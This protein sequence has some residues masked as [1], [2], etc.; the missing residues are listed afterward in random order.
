MSFFFWFIC[1]SIYC[2]SFLRHSD[3][4]P[5]QVFHK[6]ARL[7]KLST[8]FSFRLF[9]AYRFNLHVSQFGNLVTPSSENPEYKACKLWFCSALNTVDY[10]QTTKKKESRYKWNLCRCIFEGIFTYVRVIFSDE[11]S[12][13]T[14]WSWMSKCI[15]F[16]WESNGWIKV[17][18]RSELIINRIIQRLRFNTRRHFAALHTTELPSYWSKC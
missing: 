13:F 5:M 16:F 6:V 2:L 8:F 1:C 18:S 4:L 17:R 12:W 14:P 9:V 11:S 10:G 15:S 3:E 7:W